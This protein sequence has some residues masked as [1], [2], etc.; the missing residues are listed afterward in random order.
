MIITKLMRCPV[1]F[2]TGCI[3]ARLAMQDECTACGKATPSLG[4]KLCEACSEQKE[5]C[6]ECQKP[7]AD[8]KSYEERFNQTI[9]KFNRKASY[10]PMYES[11]ANVAVK[12]RDQ[13]INQDRSAVLEL[14]KQWA[15]GKNTQ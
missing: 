4:I 11:F 14:C 13:I 3:G 1:C 10:D 12:Y 5:C 7:I 8:G 6:A 2:V 9:D 15:H